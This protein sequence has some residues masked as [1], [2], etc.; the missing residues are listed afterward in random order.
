MNQNYQNIPTDQICKLQNDKKLISFHDRL[1]AA[2]PTNYGQLH[3]KGE[4]SENNRKVNSLIGVSIQDYSNGTGERNIITHFN[5]APEQVQFFLTRITAGFLEYE[6]NTSKIFGE[7]D[8]NGYSTAQQFIISRHSRTTNGQ[9]M[10]NPWRV[11]I[12]NGRGIKA[13]N[14]NGGSYIRSGSFVTEKTAFIQLTDM[15]L[16][17]LLKRVDAYITQWENCI[18][19]PLFT[20]GKQLLTDRLVQKQRFPK[21]A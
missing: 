15:D 17:Q 10:K 18:A 9:E 11:Q 12:V 1:R 8:Q 7:A 14:K 2:L 3:C 6:W 5:L 16:Y 21:A 4:Y 20:N 13:F 19:T